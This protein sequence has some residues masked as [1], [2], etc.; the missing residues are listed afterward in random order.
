MQLSQPLAGIGTRPTLRFAPPL[1]IVPRS[2]YLKT[3]HIWRGGCSSLAKIRRDLSHG[4]KL[5]VTSSVS[6][7]TPPF[8]VVNFCLVTHAWRHGVHPSLDRFYDS[9]GDPQLHRSDART[10]TT[11][12]FMS[13]TPPACLACLLSS[14]TSLKMARY[15]DM[16]RECIRHKGLNM[17]PHDRQS[18]DVSCGSGRPAV[19]IPRA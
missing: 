5:I 14:L 19:A 13:I 17:G 16:P 4:V 9:A 10:N 6:V 12:S 3:R 11:L 8:V 2:D 7:S 1:P 15:V 18:G